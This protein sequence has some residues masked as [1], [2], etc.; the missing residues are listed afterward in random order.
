MKRI[1]V[2]T[3]LLAIAFS[4]FATV[5]RV[6]DAD[7]FNAAVKQLQAGDSVIMASGVWQDAKLV[8][9]RAHGTQ[10]SPVIITVEEKGKTTLEGASSI[11][12][13]GEYVKVEGLVFQNGGAG[14]RHVIEFRTSSTDYA[15]HSV[16]SECVIKDYNPQD[17]S[18]HSDW[19]SLWGKDNTVQYCYFA[20]KT[21]QGTTFIVWPNDSLSQE[22]HH[23]IRRNYFGY[24]KPLG[25]NGGETMRIGTSHVS[26]SNSQTIVEGNYFEHCD[27]EVEIVSVKSCENI[28]RNNTFYECEGSVVLRH[29]DRNEVCGNLFVGNGKRHT[30]GVRIVN[31]GQHV[32]HNIFYKLAGK[33][34][35]AALSIMNGIYDTPLNGYHQVKDAVIEHNTFVSCDHPFELCVGKG[36]RDRDA[37]PQRTRVS[38]N[39]VYCPTAT[40]LVQ[41]YDEGYDITFSRNV[42][43]SAA[44][45]DP[46]SATTEVQTSFWHDLF[47]PLADDAS[48]GAMSGRVFADPAY[49]TASAANCGPA[50]YK[51][52]EISASKA[53][54]APK[55]WRPEQGDEALGKAIRKAQA[56]DIIELADGT[57]TLTKK[58]KVLTNLTIRAA[59]GAKPVLFIAGDQSTIIGFEIG[60][61]ARLTV[62][63]VVVRGDKNGEP[64]AK[65]C[66]TA[67][68]ES[69]S[70]YSLVIDRCEI[71]GFMVTDGGALF[72]AYKN[73][74]ADSIIVRNCDIH[75]CYRGF[76]L[77][78]E[79]EE[80]GLYNA[81][82]VVFENT[83][84][85]A[86]TQWAVDYNRLGQDESTTG[87]ALIVNHCVFDEV[88]DR[89]D[90][91]ILRQ[92]GIKRVEIT[93]TLF[94]NSS[95]KWAVRL[96]G[97]AH[98]AANC[99]VYL[100]GKIGTQG[101]ARAE[102]IMT[103]KPKFQK[104]SYHTHPKSPLAG[105][106]T[107]GG[108]IG[109]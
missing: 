39:M 88:N 23:L 17:K 77:A 80:K 91:T 69:A 63:G 104:K 28:I 109:L 101:G 57:Y 85:H 83:V 14:V 4:S 78:E 100:C 13:S 79:K 38:S 37:R 67:N 58:A 11:R 94:M 41:A 31:E 96:V 97:A 15:N 16:L 42:M 1:L 46:S 61:D 3:T 27:G 82:V 44:G 26:K 2:L 72:K 55:T 108:N 12:F 92:K 33:E 29:G 99:N 98:R 50:W 87:G 102:G 81:E 54:R 36:F 52:V 22:N 66:F 70:N 48:I 64:L 107:D 59:E 106:A 8:V 35:R 9:K 34:F 7:G 10:E 84:F 6:S 30:G 5:H 95:S 103:A 24:R 56:G 51:P 49:E 20:G 89:D 53:Q 71:S 76:A 32:H 105:V 68:K 43:F 40:D 90:Q 65:Y 86:I 74:F 21:N 25:S 73:T 75:D 18:E 60:N 47:I 19:I 62:E 45:F 93:N